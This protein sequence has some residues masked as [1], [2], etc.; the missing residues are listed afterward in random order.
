MD[1]NDSLLK[2]GT[3]ISEDVVNG[4]VSKL[5]RLEE[6]LADLPT[7]NVLTIELQLKG[8][9]FKNSWKI[10]V[11]DAHRKD[12]AGEVFVTA[13][14][15]QALTALDKGKKVLLSPPLEQ[16]KG[17]TGKFVPVFWSPVHFPNQPGTMGI[18]CDPEHPVF[19]EFPTEFHSNWH[20]W[21]ISKFSETLEID[22]L[23][24]EPLITVMDNFFKNRNLSNLFEARVGKGYLVF[25]SIDL[26]NNL[27]KRLATKQL[28]GSILNY[29]N[30][31]E[32]VPS[33]TISNEEL[34]SLQ[35]VSESEVPDVLSIYN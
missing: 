23:D 30:S 9:A 18:L 17:I 20:W 2:T 3:F 22:Q 24:V 21:D 32:F 15:E 10:W 7:P 25:S 35:E 19:N 8:T 16:M 31:E 6:S 12:E 26:V 11:Y 14:F 13:S 29:M 5:G 34:K 28:K 1:Q 33:R 4:S 27:D